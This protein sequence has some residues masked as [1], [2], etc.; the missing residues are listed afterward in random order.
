MN[1][2]QTYDNKILNPDLPSLWLEDMGLPPTTAFRQEIKTFRTFWR[3]KFHR[4]AF[5]LLMDAPTFPHQLR[6]AMMMILADVKTARSESIIQAMLSNGLSTTRN[7]IYKDFVKYGV[8]VTFWD[9]VKR[10]IGYQETSP[11]LDR[12]AIH[13]LLTASTYTIRQELLSELEE[14]ISLPNQTYCYRLVS[15]WLRCSDVLFRTIYEIAVYVE[16]NTNLPE[17]FSQFSITDLAETEIFPCV[18]EIILEKLMRDIGKRHIIDIKT[19][20]QTVA[21]RRSYVWYDDMRYFYEGLLQVANMRAFYQ[22]RSAGF[23]AVEP[24]RVWIEYTSHDYRMDTYYRRFHWNYTR[25]LKHCHPILSDLFVTVKNTVESLYTQW[26]LTELNGHWSDICADTLRDY[27]KILDIP[28]QTSFYRRQ[29][30]TADGQVYVIV[31][32]ALRYEVAV[33]LAKRLSRE[34][35]SKVSISSMQSI[36]P[37]I[38]K[39]G[40]AALLPHKKLSVRVTTRKKDRLS[41]LADGQSTEASRRD[42]LLKAANPQ[43]I[44]LKYQDIINLK[45]AERKEMVKCMEIIY[46]YHDTIDEAGHVGTS[47]FEA[48]VTAINELENLVRMI[49]NEFGGSHIFITADHGFLYTDKPLK[50]DDKVDKTTPSKQDIEVG[51][52]YAVMEKNAQ[53]DYLLPVR[54]LDGGAKY[55]AFAPRENIRIKTKGG[56]MNFVHGGISLQEMVVPVIDYRF[57]RNGNV[58][59]NEI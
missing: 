19:I 48:C 1:D 3:V 8:D 14:F 41:V 7:R 13:L 23:H 28:E 21:T 9:I 5:A 37:T 20:Q 56:G 44:A 27:G 36:F 54:F 40:M 46:L 4:Q 32:D 57:C 17:R 52:R 11:T 45:V 47:I 12:L 25:S 58:A 53:P 26:F 33:S 18:H 30:E 51:R 16:K 38:T 2:Q 42:K 55:A 59:A 15:E 43:S 35:H 50:E 31:S 29:V 49:V 24:N 39:F 6:M 34:S 22:T 10:D